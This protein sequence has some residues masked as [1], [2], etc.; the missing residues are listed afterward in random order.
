MGV[1]SLSH[2]YIMQRLWD[3][4][5]ILFFKS[6]KA[7][8]LRSPSSRD[9]QCQGGIL[10]GLKCIIKKHPPIMY[11]QD[12]TYTRMPCPVVECNT[13]LLTMTFIFI[14]FPDQQA[15]CVCTILHI[16]V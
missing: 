7:T 6:V 9:W 10:A 4:I 15:R 2:T 5:F 14:K 13:E 11:T 8:A 1:F 16:H 3:F 12:L